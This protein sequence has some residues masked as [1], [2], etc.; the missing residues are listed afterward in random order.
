MLKR[1]YPLFRELKKKERMSVAIFLSECAVQVI[2]Y[3]CAI[4]TMTLILSVTLE[5]TTERLTQISETAAVVM[6]V[7][8]CIPIARNTRLRLRDAGYT[9]KAYLW[10]LLPGLGWLVFLALLLKKGLPRRPDG[11]PIT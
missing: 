4:V 1:K 9:A 7:L 6:A 10:L 5:V 8:W 3:I 11:T 2:S